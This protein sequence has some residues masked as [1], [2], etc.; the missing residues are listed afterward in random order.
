MA[1]KG[2][3]KKKKESRRKGREQVEEGI[4]EHHGS[5][6]R[7]PIYVPRGKNIISANTCPVIPTA[8]YNRLKDWVPPGF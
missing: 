3:Q 1:E 7:R 2:L 8:Q 6:V 5:M 4:L